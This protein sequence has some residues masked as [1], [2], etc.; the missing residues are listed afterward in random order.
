MM[1]EQVKK[2]YPNIHKVLIEERNY[3]MARK[4][5]HLMAEHADK[6]IV[7]VVGAGHE[8]DILAILRENEG[9]SYSFTVGP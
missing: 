8:E 1:V 5:K 7:A 2:R 3:Y 6:K 9:V 4:I